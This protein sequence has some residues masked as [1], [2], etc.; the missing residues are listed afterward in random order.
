M[1]SQARRLCLALPFLPRK[2]Q[3]SDLS[4][5]FSPW[6]RT[7]L[8]AWV[9]SA[10]FS[11]QAA[12]WT[13]LRG[14][15]GRAAAIVAKSGADLNAWDAQGNPALLVAALHGN[16]DAVRGLLEAGV[17][18]N[19]TNRAGATALIYSVSDPAKVKLLLRRGAN[20]NHSSLHGTTPLIAAAGSPNGLSS[21]HRTSQPPSATSTWRSILIVSTT[22]DRRRRTNPPSAMQTPRGRAVRRPHT[23]PRGRGIGCLLA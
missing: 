18:V 21:A 1:T 23:P 9:L 5:G 22:I 17:D 3:A 13:S 7:S 14:G 20:P 11:V 8:V 4:S 16:A 2:E 6:L 10:C 12:D 15:D 19:A